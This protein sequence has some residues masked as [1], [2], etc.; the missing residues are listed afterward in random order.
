[1]V[2]AGLTTSVRPTLPQTAPAPAAQSGWVTIPVPFEMQV[3]EGGRQVGTTAT[4][5]LP[6]APGR[7]TLDIVSEPLAFRTSV[8]V[9]VVAGRET[10]VPVTL[11]NGTAAINAIPWA[12]VWIDGQKAGETPIGSMALTLGP[13]ELVFRHPEFPERRHVVSIT[14]GAPTR[15]SV[16]MKP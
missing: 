13:H 6:L 7:H 9:D 16:E 12:E 4:S 15:V 11:P 2:E 1:M 3:L 8:S 10:R 5:R 14:A